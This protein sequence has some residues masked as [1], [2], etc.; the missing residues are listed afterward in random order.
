MKF[1]NKIDFNKSY[2][3][4]KKNENFFNNLDFVIIGSGPASA[5]LSYFLK[6]K[7]KNFLVIEKGN[8]EKGY[9][10][11][12]K[13]LNFKIHEESRTFEVGGSGNLWANIYSKFQKHEF[14]NRFNRKKKFLWPFTVNK[15]DKY[16]K[17]LDGKFG[18]NLKSF[19]FEE[20]FLQKNF[21]LRKFLVNK[22][23]YNF[24]YFFQKKNNFFLLYNC[25]VLSINENKNNVELEIKNLMNQKLN[26]MIKKLIICSGGLESIRL[27]LK[28]IKNNKLVKLKNKK[29]VGRYF[30]DHPKGYVGI[31]KYPKRKYLS[32]LALKSSRKFFSYIGLSLKETEQIDK[33]LVNTYVRFEEYNL[34]TNKFLNYFNDKF[35]KSYISKFHK[36]QI[37]IFMEMEPKYNNCVKLDKNDNL[38]ISLEISKKELA[39]AN[40]L[41]KRIFYNL[42]CDFKKEDIKNIDK[43][44][45]IDAS[46]HIGGLVYPLIV[47]QNLKF[48]GLKNIY[49][50]SSSIFPTSGSVNPTLTIC[51]F[52]SR[53]ANYLVQ[54]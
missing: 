50:C 39:T 32:L 8:F 15:L 10:S 14:Y 31:L 41:L 48:N 24:K 6:K 42:S 21:S 18:F 11:K 49:C 5:V 53:L 25:E 19:C 29:F 38:L 27:I 36:Y 12:I 16:Y 33:R 51:A 30:M 28:S 52:A 13:S 2:H 7:K 3:N 23:P 26:I 43:S 44:D 46:H 40:L 35:L 47:D 4:V 20:K 9:N 45:L 17:S 34:L 54:K 1:S 37:K 22:I